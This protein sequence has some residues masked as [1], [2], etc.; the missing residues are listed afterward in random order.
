M[1]LRNAKPET[2]TEGGY[3]LLTVLVMVFLVLLALAVAAPRVAKQIQRDKEQEAIQRGLQYKRA[4]R[5]YYKKFGAYPSDVK[6]LEN[7]N[8]IRF[9]RKRYKDPLTGQDDWRLIHMGEAKVPPLGFFGQP[10]QAGLSSASTGPGLGNGT[11]GL[12]APDT[13]GVG[14]SANGTGT[15]GSGANGTASGDGSSNPTNSGGSS[16]GFNNNSN[17]NT[18]GSSSTGSSGFGFNNG[19]ST[20][21]SGFGSN[22]SSSTGSSGFGFNNNNSTSPTTGVGTTPTSTN[23]PGASSTGSNNAFGGGAIVGIGIPVKKDSLI[24]YHK[25]K[26][27]SDWEFVYD[28]QEELLMAGGGLATGGN[29]NGA[30]ANGNAAGIGTSGTNGSSSSSSGSGFGFN[31]GNSGSSGSGFGFNNGNSG[32]SGFNSSPGSGPSTP[33]MPSNPQ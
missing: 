33:T 15:N 14:G 13:P 21:S 22:S 29:V 19:S 1:L 16:F 31:N 9:L 12:Y 2:K 24:L 20:G 17:S 4:I 23:G 30:G 27:Y 5:L 25:Q 28:P 32:G 3:L 6:Q 26:K 8:Q 7:T 11:P 18:L 10:L